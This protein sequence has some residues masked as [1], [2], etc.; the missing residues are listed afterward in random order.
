MD[1][2]TGRQKME[3]AEY[4]HV[5]LNRIFEIAKEKV[6]VVRIG[7]GSNDKKQ[8][9]NDVREAQKVLRT[10][11][12]RISDLKA[13]GKDIPSLNDQK[14]VKIHVES[15]E[16]Q[17][18]FLQRK[19]KEGS[20]EIRKDIVEEERRSL[21]MKRDGTM[22]TGNIKIA[23]PQ[24]RAKALTDLNAKMAELVSGGEQTMTTLAHSSSVLGNTHS[25]Y[26]NQKALI[27]T[28]SK[29]LSKYEQREITEKFLLFFC[30]LFYCAV[31]LYILQK[32]VFPWFKIF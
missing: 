15:H 3:E 1:Q 30:F 10:M 24:V 11:Q 9:A 21:L 32:R 14:T 6:E 27:G 12:T 7:N 19:L 16:K 26:D 18:N 28:S 25:E 20:E 23:A 29:L 8:L 2:K 17:M 13:L 4:L 31:C 5:G 22:A